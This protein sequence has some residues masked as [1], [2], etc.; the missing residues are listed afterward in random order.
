MPHEP[1]GQQLRELVHRLARDSRNPFI[2]IAL[3]ILKYE[4]TNIP[5]DDWGLNESRGQACEF[6][7][8]QFLCH[9]NASEAVEFLLEELPRPRSN[10]TT[11]LEI[12]RGESGFGFTCETETT[13]LISG[14]SSPLPSP[15]LGQ[16]TR[17]AQNASG[18]DLDDSEGQ[19]NDVSQYSQFFG[20]NALEVAAVGH[21][22]KFLSQQVIQRVVND[23]WKGEIVFWDS[24]TVNSKKKPQRFNR[25]TADPYSRLR[26]P[27]YRKMFEA[28]FF[29][30]FLFLYYSVL[31]ERRENGIGN[32]EVLMDIWIIA[33]AYD[34]LSGLVDAG[35]L[36]YQ[37]DFWSLWN[38]GII[39]VGLVFIITSK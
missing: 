11:I 39:G 17:L 4:F 5:D 12:E 10:S 15:A 25:K 13:P 7:A 36:F 14:A 38:L 16:R 34:E 19:G 33:F 37:M 23:I 35:V 28:A 32:F 30:S 22:K 27:V 8:W 9:L 18:S 31:L 1:R 20:L 29:L 6:V 24:L 21:A 26:V 3:M 2:I